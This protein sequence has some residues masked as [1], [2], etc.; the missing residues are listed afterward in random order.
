MFLFFFLLPYFYFCL[1]IIIIA[2]APLLG[3]FFGSGSG[4]FGGELVA[5]FF[6][7][8]RKICIFFKTAYLC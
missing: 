7:K 3:F 8:N 4:G 2:E 6:L 1:D 5:W